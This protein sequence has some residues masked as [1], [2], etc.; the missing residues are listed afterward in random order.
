[1]KVKKAFMSIGKSIAVALFWIA[2]WGIVSFRVNSEFLLPSP[3]TV[4]KALYELAL[5]AEFWTIAALSLVRVVLA[6]L[7]SLVIGTA[8][9]VITSRIALF[10]TLLSPVIGVIKSTPVASFIILALLWIER[11][12]LPVFITALIVVPIVWSN[13]SE[14]I[15]STDKSLMDVAKVYKFSPLKKLMRLYVPS[16]A[17]F[18]M[19]ACRSSL[20]MAWKAGISAEILSTPQKAIGTELYFSKTYLETPTLFAWTLVV[21]VL[22]I[23]IEKL[24]VFGIEAMGRKLRVLRKGDTHDKI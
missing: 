23:I 7:F 5:S 22:S 13:V 9:A 24:F 15:R 19:A 8:L 16:V 3:T 1:M 14:G 21:I 17:P 11:D 6:I 10:D 12:L 2:V 4:A 20:G 18:F